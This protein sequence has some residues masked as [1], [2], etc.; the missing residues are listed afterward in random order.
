MT[1]F[2]LLA[3]LLLAA[4]LAARES[5]GVYENWAAFK[6]PSPLR[7][8]AI[9]KAE[10]G[11]IRGDLATEMQNNVTHGSDSPESAA[12][13]VA[14]FGQRLDIMPERREMQTVADHQRRKPCQPA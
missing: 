14:L 9:A 5:L 7:C 4:P 11:T 1:R 10:M 13:E 3:L 12:R 6:D 2:A 8:Y